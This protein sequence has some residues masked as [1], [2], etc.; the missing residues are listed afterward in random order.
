M[1]Y[2]VQYRVTVFNAVLHVFDIFV[3]YCSV[4]T[5]Y[6]YCRE[7]FCLVLASHLRGCHCHVW[8]L[9]IDTTTITV[10]CMSSILI[11][12]TYFSVHTICISEHYRAIVSYI[13]TPVQ[14]VS[15]ILWSIT[16]TVWLQS[17]V[18]CATFFLNEWNLYITK[19][20][21]TL[22]SHYFVLPGACFWTTGRFKLLVDW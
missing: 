9:Y 13:P 22:H 2:S 1:Y 3:W 7:L 12:I 17:Q 19:Y 14:R 20:R 8:V 10:W 15:A 21:N 5:Q 4:L 18:H 16:I 6:S 11:H